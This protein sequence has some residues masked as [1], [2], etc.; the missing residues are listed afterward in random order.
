MP[1]EPVKVPANPFLTN[2]FPSKRKTPLGANHGGAS[3][4]H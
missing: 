4:R 3:G 1:Y 2:F